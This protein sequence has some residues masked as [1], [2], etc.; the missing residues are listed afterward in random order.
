MKRRYT[1]FS[2]SII[3]TDL[4]STG[5]TYKL[6]I[7]WRFTVYFSFKSDIENYLP[8]YTMTNDNNLNTLSDHTFSFQ[9]VY[10][11]TK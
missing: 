5:E 6:E 4:Q 2:K 3:L 7:H 9:Q 8:L 11:Q 1:R 10:V